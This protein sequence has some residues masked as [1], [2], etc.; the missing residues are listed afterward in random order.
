MEATLKE[1]SNYP[2]SSAHAD[3]AVM[4]F[5]LFNEGRLPPL[6]LFELGF[7]ITF[8]IIQL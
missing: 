2:S 3:D 6:S 7:I 8:S 1:A 4:P 5:D